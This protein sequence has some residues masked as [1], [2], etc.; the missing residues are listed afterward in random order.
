MLLT[1][2]RVFGKAPVVRDEPLREAKWVVEPRRA[3]ALARIEELW[4]YRRT[5]WFLANRSRKRMYQRMTLGVFWVFGRPLL[6]I[7]FGTLIFGSLLGIPS[8][9]LPYFL[10]FLTGSASWYTFE[11]GLMWTTRSLQQ[12]RGLVKKVYFP[13]LLIP[14]ASVAPAIVEFGVYMG[15]LA[16]AFVYYRVTK[17][18][19]YF[20]LSWGLLAA[21]LA[22]IIA[23]GLVI[24]IGFF[25]SLAQ[26]RHRDVRYSLRYVL[27]F[28][29]YGT[30]LL[31][32]MSQ[33]P[34][35]YQWLMYMNPMA[36]VVQTFKW[37]VLGVD[38]FP[39]LPLLWSA[40]LMGGI[41]AYGF[42]FFGRAETSAIDQM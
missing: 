21:L 37:G 19:W 28:W 2:R 7:L 35:Q 31:Y 20:H 16:G 33:V 8:D 5:F 40:I 41:F 39:A 24:G 10:F 26:A 6:P 34:E 36:A 32:P 12:N 15:L 30:P 14:L 17:G 18:I 1:L 29:S 9:G 22:Q 4:H 3:G 13:R 11:R 27:R 38:R 42:W 23:L 25:T